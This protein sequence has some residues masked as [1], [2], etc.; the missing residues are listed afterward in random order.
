MGG[1]NLF[2]ALE[3]SAQYLEKFGGHALAAGLTISRDQLPAFKQ[4]ICAYARENIHDEDLMPVVDIDCLITPDDIS[5]EAIRDLGILEPYGMGNREPV[6][7]V[8]ELTVEEITAQ[9]P[10]DARLYRVMSWMLRSV[11]KSTPSAGGRT[12]N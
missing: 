11:W 9:D 7:A 1:F 4:S 6:F 5:L 12:F 2:E 3:N 8:R 10:V